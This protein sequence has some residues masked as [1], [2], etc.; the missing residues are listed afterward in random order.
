MRIELMHKL[1]DVSSYIYAEL[2][3]EYSPKDLGNAFWAFIKSKLLDDCTKK[4]KVVD[5]IYDLLLKADCDYYH[6]KYDINLEAIKKSKTQLTFVAEIVTK[7]IKHSQVSL[8]D[9]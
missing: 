6:E 5:F 4:I 7:M 9:W 1:L 3:D 8:I 2:T